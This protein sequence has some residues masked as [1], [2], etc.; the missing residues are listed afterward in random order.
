MTAHEVGQVAD[1]LHRYRLVEQLKR[2]I[3]VDAKAPAKPCRIRREAIVQF[4]AQPAQFLAQ[5]GDVRTEVREVRSNR[6]VALGCEKK[7]R[8]LAL[9]V[10]HPEHLSQGHGLVVTGV[11]E[12][13]KDDGIAVLV[14]QRYRLGRAGHFIAFGFVVS[15][16]VGAQ[17]AF[18]VV[19]AGSP[20]IG[21]AVG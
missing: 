13:A 8:R 18:L 7:A 6:Q 16:D 20:V 10:L 3:V 11:V 19:R 2:L 15:K 21:D 12:H 5:L 17:R 9:R 4:G 1:R 14:A